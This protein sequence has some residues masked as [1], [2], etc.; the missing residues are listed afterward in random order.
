[1][2]F[3]NMAFVIYGIIGAI[4]AYQGKGFRYVFIG[5]R[6]EKGKVAK[7]ADSV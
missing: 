4:M 2:I 1:M 6:I 3:G 5:N 7:P